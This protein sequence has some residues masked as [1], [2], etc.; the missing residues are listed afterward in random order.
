MDEDQ[1][2]RCRQGSKPSSF[3]VKCGRDGKFFPDPT[4]SK[5][6]DWCATV[7][8]DLEDGLFVYKAGRGD[9][10]AVQCGQGYSPEQ[11]HVWCEKSRQFKPQPRCMKKADK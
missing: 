3:H 10:V 1:L 5:I 4:C 9:R 6:E 8:S 7:E 2:V 11:T